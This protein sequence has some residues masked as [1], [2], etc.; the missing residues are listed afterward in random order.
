MPQP[1]K[2]DIVGRF[3]S[4]EGDD[5]PETISLIAKAFEVLCRDGKID[6]KPIL[7][8]KGFEKTVGVWVAIT[9]A[10]KPTT[11]F[12]VQMHFDCNLGKYSVQSTNDAD[13]SE[14]PLEALFD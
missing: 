1:F 6:E 8:L 4:I 12:W 3:V 10:T 11:C 2:I 13:K 9:N 7:K 14:F 5:S